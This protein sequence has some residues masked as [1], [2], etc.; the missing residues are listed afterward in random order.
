[1]KT[2]YRLTSLLFFLIVIPNFSQASHISGGDITYECIGPNQYFIT[3]KLFR[4]CSGTTMS[5]TSSIVFTNSCGLTNPSLTL[6]LQDPA[7]NANCAG[8]VASCATEISQLCPTQISNS[9]CNGGTLPGMQLYTYTGVVTLPGVCNTWTLNYG[10]CCR[11]PAVNITTATSY[12]YHVQTTM[13]TASEA[14]NNSPKF[15]SQPIPYVCAGQVVNYNYGVVET[16]GDSLVYS[17]VEGLQNAT[18]PLPYAAGYTGAVPIPGI[19]INA[20]T[21]QINFTPSTIGN[22]VVAIKVEEYRNGVLIGTTM[23]DIQFVV[24]SCSN[25]VPNASGGAIYNLTGSAIQTGDFTLDLCEGDNFTFNASFTDPNSTDVLTLISNIT[26]V[27]PGATFSYSGSNPVTATVSWLAPGGTAGTNTAFSITVN[28]GACP[29]PGTQTVIYDINVLEGTFAGPDLYYCPVGGPVQLQ[30]SGGSVFSWS[31]AAGLSCT[32]CPNPLASPSVTTTYVVTS[33]LSSVSCRVTDTVTVQVVPD[34]SM[35]MN[36]TSA[37][38]CKYGSVQLNATTQALYAPYIYSWTPATGLSNPNI[39]NPIA[40]PLV[41][42]TYTLSAT[43]S[44]GC[45]RQQSVTVNIVGIAPKVLVSAIDSTICNGALT[46]LNTTI[47]PDACTTTTLACSSPAQTGTIGTGTS[48]STTY[49]PHYLFTTSA[50][51]NRKQYIFLKS[52]LDAM[53]FIGG[54]RISSLALDYST[55]NTEA[56]G[57]VIKM[58]CTSLVEYIDNDWVQGMTTVKNSFNYTPSVGWNTFTLDNPYLWDGL[59]NLIVEFCV[60]NLQSGTGSSVRYGNVGFYGCN[61]RNLYNISGVCSELVGIRSVYRPNMQ[62]SY[63]QAIPAGLTYNWTPTTGLSNPNIANPLA[64]PTSTTTYMLNVSDGVCIGSDNIEITVVPDFPLSINSDTTVCMNNPVTLVPNASPTYGPYTYSWSPSAG[65]SNPNIENP[66]ATPTATTTYTASVSSAAGCVKTISITIII[67]GIAPKVAP[68]A[69]DTSVCP[70]VANQLNTLVYPGLCTTTTLACS[71]PA[72]TGTIGTGTF[73][74]TT[75][76]PHYLSTS[77]YSNRKQFIFLKSELDAMG[78][79]G[80]GRINSIALDYTTANSQVAGI[81][82][83]M[84]CTSLVE[85]ID[86]D[87]IQGMTTV[88]NSFNYTPSVGWNTFALDNPYLW[89]G[90][91]NLVVEFCADDLQTGTGSSVRYGNVGFYGC[92]YRNLFNVAGVCSELT[93]IR[94]LQRPN[95]QFT[96]CQATPAGFTYNWTPTTGLNNPNIA[97]PSSTIYNNTTYTV[98]VSDGSSCMG[99]GSIDVSIDSTNYVI[100]TPNPDTTV[101]SGDLVQLG[102]SFFGTLPPVF[103]PSCG[104]N[105]TPCSQT[106]YTQ[107]V[108]SGTL[109]SSTYSP[110]YGSYTD[111]K[112][113]FLFLAA[114]LNAAGINSGTIREIAWNITTKSSTGQ[115]SNFTISIGCTNEGGLNTTT[116]WLPTTQVWGATNYTTNLGLNNFTLANTFDWD[117]ISNIVIQTCFN[118]PNATTVGADAVQ[119][120]SAVGYLATMRNYNSA[121]GTNGCTMAP[122]YTYTARPNMQFTVCPPPPAALTY[123]WSPSGSVSNSTISNPTSNPTTQTTY[124]VTVTGGK[125]TVSDETTVYMC[126]VLPIELL[127]FKGKKVGKENLLD[128]TTQTEINND[129]FTLERSSDGREFISLGKIKGAG[130]SQTPKDY[131]FMDKKPQE[132]INYYRLKQTDFDG[133]VSY[134]ELIP[135]EN[136]S[137]RIVQAIYPNPSAGNYNIEISSPI[138]GNVRLEIIDTYGRT[139]LVK[140]SILEKGLSTLQIEA[141]NLAQGIYML[142]ISMD[143]TE[144]SEITRIVKY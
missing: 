56:T 129:Y 93:G 23:R 20:Q 108:G 47:Y 25:T 26:S 24:Q 79:V 21:G 111:T 119:Y 18:T 57:I 27:L 5:S 94:T 132:G 75:Y 55:A 134:S 74:S 61:Y 130:N 68:I 99:N 73:T 54:G 66:I 143:N 113:Q 32:N 50:Y 63:C 49:G 88:K 122:S 15:T 83:K 30:V 41:T 38:I 53:G 121:N 106:I 95:M 3:L 42:T 114:D 51:S 87:W 12:N 4:D 103:L 43:S 80:G 59:S 33:D 14:C 102:T 124:T 141:R 11:N 120:T 97:N 116:G 125:C 118:N 138:Y 126:N 139:V 37:N 22:F 81:V 60:D 58:G 70:G 7:T 77:A 67:N 13:N 19:T 52:E 28:D 45:T 36:P 109:S 85:Y 17:L 117:G 90:L 133:T 2:F 35:V 115:F 104:T 71:N 62:F 1:M 144:Y 101:C 86:N 64:S 110:F 140:N 136:V 31:P 8:T 44:T 48:T 135:L 89:D 16:D 82:I 91:S 72:Q 46:Q 78:F 127:S 105:N 29:V 92:N 100:V 131:N 6:Y 128:W 39:S 123:N 65:L 98:S 76:S 40:S 84:G 34:F 137:E 69:S 10:L 112:Y 96:F 142:K 107:Q 9:T